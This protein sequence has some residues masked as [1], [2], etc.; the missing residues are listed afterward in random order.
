MKKTFDQIQYTGKVNDG[1]KIQVHV[2]PNL[3]D[4]QNPVCLL[5]V[6]VLILFS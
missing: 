5:V 3:F 6:A 4:K 2:I 1:R